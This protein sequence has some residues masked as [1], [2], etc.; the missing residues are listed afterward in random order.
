MASDATQPICLSFLLDIFPWIPTAL[1]PSTWT[2]TSPLRVSSGSRASLWVAP[3]RARALV[4]PRWM[5]WR[6]WRFGLPWM[7]GPWCLTPCT[8]MTVCERSSHWQLMGVFP[9]SVPITPWNIFGCVELAN[10]ETEDRQWGLVCPTRVPGD[11]HGEEPL[12]NPGSER[13]V[14]GDQDRFHAKGHL[15]DRP[16]SGL[17][18][19]TVMLLM[20][21]GNTQQA[22]TRYTIAEFEWTTNLQKAAMT[23]RSQNPLLDINLC[24]K[25]QAKTR[26]SN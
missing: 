4:E 1:S 18:V 11:P 21:G 26:G 25:S 17:F 3:C 13:K 8:G 5:Q 2:W 22:Q 16:P 9:T 20:A 14:L 24:L 10:F 15:I 12:P 23:R 19:N 7:L 6:A